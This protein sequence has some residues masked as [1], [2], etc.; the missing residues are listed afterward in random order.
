MQ[1]VQ[2]HQMIQEQ[3]NMVYWV[4]VMHKTN[5]KEIPQISL[6][7]NKYDIHTSKW[8]LEEIINKLC[9]PLTVCNFANTDQ[10][11]NTYRKTSIISHTLVGNKIVDNSDV[12]GAS[13]VG[14]APTT[15]SF[16]T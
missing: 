9:G 8:Q 11:I 16:S 1:P 2:G 12:V 10:W 13:P 14:V 3:N 5:N 15:S 6:Q 4:L 7:R